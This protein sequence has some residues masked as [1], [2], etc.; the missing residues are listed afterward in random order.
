MHGLRNSVKLQA[1]KFAVLIFKPIHHKSGGAMMAENR[2]AF[3]QLTP[4]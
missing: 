3:S 1:I 2:N 4:K